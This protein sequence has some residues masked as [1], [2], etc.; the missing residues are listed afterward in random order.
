MQKTLL[1]SLIFLFLFPAAFSETQAWEPSINSQHFGP[2]RNLKPISLTY[3]LSWKGL[4]RAGK[5]TL[6][7]GIQDPESAS[8][9][10]CKSYG[11]STGFAKSLYPYQHN[12]VGKL[13][14]KTWKPKY[15]WAWEKDKEET[16]T[17]IVHYKKNFASSREVTKNWKTG[18]VVGR[19]SHDYRFQPLYDLMS[20]VM[21]FRSLDLKPGQTHKLVIHPGN[22]PYLVTAN[23]TGY[24]KHK[25]YKC[26][27]M[28]LN[29]QRI[30][31]DGTLRHYKKLKKAT[32]WISRDQDR[33]PIELRTKIFIGDVRATL[34]K[35]QYR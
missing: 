11:R 31:R 35:K 6:D 25:G 17:T 29:L 21:Y 2:N 32:F 33:I 4:L 15:F 12:F 19:R 34:I 16:K 24:D 20:A 13:D 22:Y 3:S 7:L 27:K 8:N 1:L 14:R 28:D 9:I 23:V 5:T 26:V 10:L 30:N 18:K